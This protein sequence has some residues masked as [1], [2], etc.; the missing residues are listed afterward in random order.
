MG[1]ITNKDILILI[2]YSGNTLELRNII[3]YAK[4]NKILLIGIVSDKSSILYKSSNIKLLI[5]EVIESGDGIVPTS[6][7]TAQLAFGDALSIALMKI[8]KFGKLDLK[9]SS[10]RKLGNKLKTAKDIMLTKNKIPFVNENDL[11]RKA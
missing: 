4:L 5:P 9:I 2:S 10:F 11:M 3:K 7:T 6:N 1:R 8:K